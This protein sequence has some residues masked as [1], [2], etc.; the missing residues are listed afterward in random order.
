M[1]SS[2]AFAAMEL[3]RLVAALAPEAVLGSPDPVEVRDLAYDA[4][5]VTP[6][7]AFFASPASARTATTSPRRRSRTAP[8]PSSSS[9][10]S[11]R[12]SRS[13]SSRRR[14]CG[15]GDRGRRL[16][17]RADARA[18]GRRRH[19]HER[20]DD[21]RL[22]PL[23]GARG[24]RAQSRPARHGREQGRRRGAPGRPHDARGDRPPAHLPRDA[25]R[26]QPQRRARGVLAC[27]RAAP[28]RPRPLRRA[29]VHEPEPGSPRLP[30]VDGGLLRGE[31]EALHRRRSA[32]GRRQRRRRLGA[33]A[34]RRARGRQPRAARHVRLRRRRRD[35]PGA[36]RPRPVGRELQRRRDRDPR[37]A[38][39][40]ASTSRTSS[41]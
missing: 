30:R 26:R 24:R 8:S 20:Q 25:R 31:A 38:C 6:G 34:R 37:R 32:A 28:A 36:A 12:R 23:L 40:A 1:R 39:A 29:R 7:A 17:R 14:A 33:A 15:D 18:R 9:A 11:S 3:E 27:R 16:L 35:P 10:P 5:A 2:V 21:D 4:R 41:A 22:P 13:S 19:R